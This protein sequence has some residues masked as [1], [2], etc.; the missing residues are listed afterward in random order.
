MKRFHAHVTVKDL[1]ESVR[2]YSALF[3]VAPAVLREDY[4]KWMLEDPRINI[5]IS[6]CYAKS[7]KYW[8][9]DPQG[10]AW[11]AFHT[12]AAIP[13]FGETPARQPGTDAC[14][15]PLAAPSEKGT[16]AC[17]VPAAAKDAEPCCAA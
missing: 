10:V 9:T 12:L 14:C 6:T 2:F 3:D 15:V 13:V 17:C 4:A 11:E 5:A 16:A 8:V 1:A 7:D